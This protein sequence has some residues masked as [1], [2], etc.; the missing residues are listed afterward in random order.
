MVK[1]LK[2]TPVSKRRDEAQCVF[3]ILSSLLITI[4]TTSLDPL[5]HEKLK[6]T[7][8]EFGIEINPLNSSLTIVFLTTNRDA[9]CAEIFVL[10]LKS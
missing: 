10:S 9:V 4:L 3:D 1:C 5:V 8:I 6:C 7:G 2:S